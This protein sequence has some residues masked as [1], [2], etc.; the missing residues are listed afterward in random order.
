MKKS[1]ESYDVILNIYNHSNIYTKYWFNPKYDTTFLGG[2]RQRKICKEEVK[3]R[4]KMSLIFHI[5]KSVENIANQRL[6][7]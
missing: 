6:K 7:I 5:R 3:E 1:C 4:A 2:W